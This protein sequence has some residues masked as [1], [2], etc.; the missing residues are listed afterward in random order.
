[1]VDRSRDQLI[2]MQGD[3]DIRIPLDKGIAGAVATSGMAE[4][5]DDAYDLFTF[6]NDLLTRL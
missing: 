3:V 1:M 2:V 6:V 4:I 5:I